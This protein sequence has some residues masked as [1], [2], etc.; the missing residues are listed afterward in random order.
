MTSFPAPSITRWENSDRAM[1]TV[2][3]ARFVDVLNVSYCDL[4]DVKHARIA[5]LE[6]ENEKLRASLTAA[7]TALANA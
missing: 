3:I 2:H 1:S 4:L 7:R 5:A 6:A